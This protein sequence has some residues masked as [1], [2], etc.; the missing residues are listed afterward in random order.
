MVGAADALDQPLYVF[1]GADLD[2]EIDVAPVDAKIK[3]AGADDGAQIAAHHGG[4]DLFALG[5]IQAPVVDG[6]RQG[7][8]IGEPEVVKENLG[9]RAG[10]VKDQRRLVLAHL[11]K[12]RWN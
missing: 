4:F 11:L 6:D 3:R 1:G 2:D 12:H 5:A 8:F 9:L 7:V 10:V